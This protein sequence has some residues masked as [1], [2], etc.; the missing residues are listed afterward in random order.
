MNIQKYMLE[1]ADSTLRHKFSDIAGSY[2]T[3]QAGE[4]KLE[5]MAGRIAAG[6]FANPNVR[7]DEDGYAISEAV[8]VAAMILQMCHELEGSAQ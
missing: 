5:R 7:Q 4:T 3:G 1:P 2:A 6:M 8:D